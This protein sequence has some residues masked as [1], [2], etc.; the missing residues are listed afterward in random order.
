LRLKDLGGRGLVVDEG[1]RDGEGLGA[2]VGA[3]AMDVLASLLRSRT[4]HVD[5]GK[6]KGKG[7]RQAREMRLRLKLKLRKEF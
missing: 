4:A 1:E 6:G 7:K 3:E 5:V 2:D